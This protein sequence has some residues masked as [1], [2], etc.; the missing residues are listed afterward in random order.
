MKIILVT[1]YFYPITN[2]GTEKYVYLLAK[3]LSKEHNVKI[4]STHETFKTNIYENL[5]IDYIRPNSNFQKEVLK[6]ILPSNSID[7]FEDYLKQESPDIV[8]FHTLTTN[9]NHFQI[10]KS[11]QLGFKTYLTTHIPGDQCPRGDFIYKGKVACDGK[12]EQSKC[13][14]CICFSS[15]KNVLKNF[16]KYLYYKTSKVNPAS[17]RLKHLAVIGNNT[18]K[19]IA[20]CKW[21]KDFLIKNG[22]ISNHIE[23]CRQASNNIDIKKSD[24]R[25]IRLGFIGRIDPLKGLHILIEALSNLDID[26]SLNIAAIKPHKEHQ[27]YFEKTL[28]TTQKI[29]SCQWLFNLNSIEISSFFKN[30]DYLVVPSI[31]LETGPF[32]VYE[33]LAAKTPVL[34]TNLGGQREL[35][36]NGENGYL[37]EP[38]A[39]SLQ[40]LLQTL[41]INSTPYLFKEP[42]NVESIAEEMIAIYSQN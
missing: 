22:M 7:F 18:N 40:E 5:K 8:H 2:G 23:I 38:N 39:K 11:F 14:K 16:V 41:K 34:T 31:G 28:A 25:E 42:R 32:V 13:L 9:F 3:Y 17:L 21:Q 30:I 15:K 27:E 24:S 6:G 20:V 36:V 19:I 1:E 12:I 26:Y 10:A 37:F 33:A 35:I 29:K 4:L